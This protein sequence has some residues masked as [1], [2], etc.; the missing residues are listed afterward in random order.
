MNAQL[1]FL[2]GAIS[3]VITSF[4]LMIFRRV[5]QSAADRSVTFD[6]E[7]IT[8]TVTELLDWSYANR[9]A[10]FSFRTVGRRLAY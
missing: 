1:S 7:V 2:A 3:L 4:F 6:D 8:L 5:K 10:G 9:A